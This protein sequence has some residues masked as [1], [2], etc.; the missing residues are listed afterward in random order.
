[1]AFPSLRAKLSLAAWLEAHTEFRLPA[2]ASDLTSA[3]DVLDTS[4]QSI[5]YSMQFSLLKRY[6]N[7]LILGVLVMSFILGLLAVPPAFATSQSNQVNIF[8]LFIILLGFHLLN[9]TA[10]FVTMTATM[11]HRS[12]NKGILLSVLIFLNKKISKHS[13]FDEETTSAY[14]H[15]QCPTQSN[16]WLVSS[17]SHGAWGCYLFAGWLMTLLLLLTNQVDFIWETT[18]L[19]DDAFIKLTQTLSIIPQWFGLSPPNQF[20]ILASRID[21]VAQESSTRQHWANFLLASIMIYGVLPR[22]I[23]TLISISMYYFQRSTLPLSNR[24]RFIQNRYQYKEEHSTVIVDNDSNKASESATTASKTEIN[25][26]DDRA[27]LQPWA[28]F[29]WS[30]PQPG[31]LNKVSTLSLLNSRKEQTL[32]LTEAISAPVYILVDA[33][34]SPDR[35]SRRFFTQVSAS[36]SSAFIA[37]ISDNESAQFVEDWQRLAKEAQL[38]F[39]QITDKD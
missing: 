35:G 24:E 30:A 17:I 10:W 2:Q 4:P 5:S 1:M 7:H 39:V 13:H 15:W 19:S 12:E 21:L 32:F 38:P 16:T 11:R 9:L 31:F 37:I 29:E 20:D 6:F 23:L 25:T 22:L 3:L 18:L 14:L 8:W 28:L 26:L 34:Q 27:F 33:S 36:Y